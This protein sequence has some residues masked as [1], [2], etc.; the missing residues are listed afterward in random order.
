MCTVT[1]LPQD[2]GYLLGMN[3]DESRRRGLSSFVAKMA[4]RHPAA[5][6]QDADKG[7]AWV[8]VNAAGLGLALLN[9]HPSRWRRGKDFAYRTRGELILSVASRHRRADAA[10]RELTAR[11]DAGDY[12]PFLII[13][14][15]R[16]S[17]PI[18]TLES[19][20]RRFKRTSLAKK[21]FL[22]S[23]SSWDE[24][25]AARS[26]RRRFRATIFFAADAQRAQRLFH[27]EHRPH[28]GPLSVCMHRKD[29]RTV[30]FTHIRVGR[31]AVALRYFPDSPCRWRP[32]KVLT[33][34][35]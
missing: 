21:P 34:S 35:L 18:E 3:R 17:G 14:V 9:R 4:G 19:D 6:P 16:S 32:R 15:D 13:G 28:R 12:P 27:A 8:A 25:A 7:G 31:S 30:S 24:D 20:G 29:A 2:D 5:Y 22:F 26:R 23:S 1:I 33:R 10:L 11:I